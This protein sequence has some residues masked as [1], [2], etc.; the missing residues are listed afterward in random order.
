MSTTFPSGEDFAN[1]ITK[2]NASGSLIY[3]TPS[4]GQ[5]ASLA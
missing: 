2:F 3:S 1:F 5:A 4:S